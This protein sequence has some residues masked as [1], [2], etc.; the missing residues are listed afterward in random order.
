MYYKKQCPKDTLFYCIGK[1]DF[2]VGAWPCV[3]PCSF[4]YIIGKYAILSCKGYYFLISSS[5]SKLE[6]SYA[7]V[8]LPHGE[9]LSALT[10]LINSKLKIY[11]LLLFIYLYYCCSNFNK[12]SFISNP[13]AYPTNFLL[14]PIT[15]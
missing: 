8:N 2:N 4:C 3:R 6:I 10:I 13:P 14:L 15:L 9:F 12:V 5:D 7:L 1:I 11:F